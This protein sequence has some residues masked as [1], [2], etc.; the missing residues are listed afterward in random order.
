VAVRLVEVQEV[1]GCRTSW[2]GGCR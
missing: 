2:S 1:F